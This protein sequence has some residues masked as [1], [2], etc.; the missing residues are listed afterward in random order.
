M[1]IFERVIPFP[2]RL[3]WLMLKTALSESVTASTLS[4][5]LGWSVSKARQMVW[6]NPRKIRLNDVGEWFWACGVQMPQFYII[7]ATTGQPLATA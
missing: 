7:D 4:S 1:T 5:R 3:Q 6:G 2:D